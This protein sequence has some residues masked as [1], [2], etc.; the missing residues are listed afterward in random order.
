MNGFKQKGRK[1]SG[2]RYKARDAAM[3]RNRTRSA[4]SAGQSHETLSR[5]GGFEDGAKRSGERGDPC[6]KKHVECE[7]TETEDRHESRRR[8]CAFA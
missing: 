3:N 4:G 6:M 8:K 1:R 2:W 5:I 7:D